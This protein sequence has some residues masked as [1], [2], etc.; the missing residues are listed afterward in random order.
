MAIHGGICSSAREEH[1]TKG[2]AKR[3]SSSPSQP[4]LKNSNFQHPFFMAGGGNLVMMQGNQLI[5]SRFEDS[6]SLH[7]FLR[8]CYVMLCMYLEFT[9]QGGL[10]QLYL[11]TALLH[12]NPKR[13]KG[14]GSNVRPFWSF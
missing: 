12:I 8:V 13:I 2:P 7:L 1:C 3:G 10:Y 5:P 6:L 4:G 11:I 9:T 14:N